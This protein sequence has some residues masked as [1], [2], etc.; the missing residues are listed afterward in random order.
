MISAAH[1]CGRPWEAK[2]IDFISIFLLEINKNQLEINNFGGAHGKNL[3]LTAHGG[4]PRPW[5]AEINRFCHV[6]PE[7]N[8]N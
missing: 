3:D 1:G 5:A 2:N 7:I 8:K 6:H 4:R